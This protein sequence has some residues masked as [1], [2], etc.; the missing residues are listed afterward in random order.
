VVDWS[1]GAKVIN[2]YKA[3]ANTRVTAALIVQ[4][5]KALQ[6]HGKT[7]QPNMSFKSS[8]IK[9]RF[10]KQCCSDA[11]SVKILNVVYILP[12]AYSQTILRDAHFSQSCSGVEI[13]MCVLAQLLY[14]MGGLNNLSFVI[15]FPDTN[16]YTF[17]T[18]MVL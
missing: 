7:K 13:Y 11:E 16:V 5:I 10:L 2:Y 8:E 15:V 12:I 3:V 17:R 4:F 14:K 18:S 6:V 9:I 1:G